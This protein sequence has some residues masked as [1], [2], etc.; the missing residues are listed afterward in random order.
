MATGIGMATLRYY[1]PFLNQTQSFG[2]DFEEAWEIIG[3]ILALLVLLVF[4]CYMVFVYRKEVLP[5][6]KFEM[7]IS[8]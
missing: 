4:I 2:K 1:E 7:P 5:P 3:G 8:W 6:G